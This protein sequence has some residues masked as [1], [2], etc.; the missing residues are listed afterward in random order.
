MTTKQT[1][2]KT[3]T[4]KTRVQD[5]QALALGVRDDLVQGIKTR[6][7]KLAEQGQHIATEWARIL[8]G[9]DGD[10][11]QGFVNAVALLGD[12]ID[13]ATL[14]RIVPNTVK[15]G[16][17]TGYVQA[18]T[19]EKIVNLVHTI[20]QG[21]LGKLSDYSAQV[22]HNALTNGD[23]LSMRGALASLSRRVEC[24]GLSE[25][26]S[27]RANY[28]AGTASAQASQV[29]DALRI[30]GLAQVSKGKR[31]DTFTL[32]PERVSKLREVFAMSFE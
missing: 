22:L 23:A 6:T 17:R 15:T 9:I 2:R 5:N 31:D 26:I 3:R 20:A 24:E 27:K 12:A 1:T 14:V 4:Q 19:V 25:T 8:R 32:N 21:D 13:T 29:R 18:K 28:S 30:L 11:G 7:A 10:N 16:D